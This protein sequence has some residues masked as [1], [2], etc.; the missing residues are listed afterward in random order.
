MNIPSVGDKHMGLE[1]TQNMQHSTRNKDSHLEG[2]V[3]LVTQG[4][5]ERKGKEKTEQSKV[6]SFTYG[7]FLFL[8]HSLTRAT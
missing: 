2:P 8:C 1:T 3:G 5:L 4:N 7:H 6:K